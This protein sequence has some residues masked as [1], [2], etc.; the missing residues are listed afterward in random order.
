MDASV[1]S[2]AYVAQ[3][4]VVRKYKLGTSIFCYPSDSDSALSFDISISSISG[5]Y[6]ATTSFYQRKSAKT[7]KM[8]AIKAVAHKLARACYYVMRDNVAFDAEKAFM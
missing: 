5:I 8:I 3:H 6:Y 1:M 2:T 4:N 7:K